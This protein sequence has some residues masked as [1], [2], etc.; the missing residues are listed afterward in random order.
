[1]GAS[2]RGSEWYDA[3]GS[4]KRVGWSKCAVL[5]TGSS[6][7][8]AAAATAMRTNDECGSQQLLEQQRAITLLFGRHFQLDDEGHKREQLRSALPVPEVLDI[9]FR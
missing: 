3:C 6:F 7:P 5:V 4:G 9:Q 1:M 8:H 2:V